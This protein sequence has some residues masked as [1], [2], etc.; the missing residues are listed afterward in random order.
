[1]WRGWNLTA[2]NAFPWTGCETVERVVEI[3]LLKLK[4]EKVLGDKR[5]N[6]LDLNFKCIYFIEFNGLCRARG[7]SRVV[8]S[9]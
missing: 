9:N 3:V 7:S 1:M 8:R 4:L 6:Y 5:I 2:S